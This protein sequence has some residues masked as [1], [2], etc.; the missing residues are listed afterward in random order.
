VC[1]SFATA[2]GVLRCFI[3]IEST[4]YSTSPVVA[5]L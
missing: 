5:M 4:A 1:C 2:I 3:W